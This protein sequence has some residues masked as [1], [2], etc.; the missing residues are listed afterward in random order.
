METYE[1]LE[2]KLE[3]FRKMKEV[4]TELEQD[5]SRGQWDAFRDLLLKR[6][7]LQREVSKKDLSLENLRKKGKNDSA[8]Q[9][10]RRI[11]EEIIDLIQSLQAI[12]RRVEQQVLKEREDLYMEIKGLRQGKKAMKG[13][14]RQSGGDPKFIDRR[15]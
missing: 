4:A 12:D 2:Q 3:L 15:G 7:R 14:G 11:T 1:L 6:D 10:S 5:L 8:D 9:K 13:Y